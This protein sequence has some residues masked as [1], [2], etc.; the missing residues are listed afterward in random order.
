MDSIVQGVYSNAH[1]H[2]KPILKGAP[3]VTLA[4]AMG[5]DVLADGQ[6]IDLT[7][8][9]E[10]VDV[11]RMSTDSKRSSICEA[12]IT[13]AMISMLWHGKSETTSR[14]HLFPIT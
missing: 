5:N 14:V 3:T 13:S 2:P 7:Q 6:L 1:Q 10:Q 12:F 8:R 9:I 4:R 11:L